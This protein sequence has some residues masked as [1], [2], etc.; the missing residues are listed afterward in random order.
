MT[1]FGHITD[2]FVAALMSQIVAKMRSFAAE[3]EQ[4]RIV[5]LV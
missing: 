1:A 5:T 4:T 3:H 2:T